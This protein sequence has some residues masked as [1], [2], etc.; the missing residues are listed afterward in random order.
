MLLK[1]FLSLRLLIKISQ[2]RILL[3]KSKIILTLDEII[4]VSDLS[5]KH[6]ISPSCL[7]KSL[8]LRKLSLHYTEYAKLKIGVKKI[9]NELESHAWIEVDGKILNNEDITDY[10]LIYS[11][12]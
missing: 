8:A 12:T 9:N 3:P 7:V 5:F 10:E 2:S 6:I 11:E 4:Y 1:V